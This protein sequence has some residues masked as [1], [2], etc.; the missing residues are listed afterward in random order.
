MFKPFAS[1]VGKRIRSNQTRLLIAAS[2]AILAA[3]AFTLASVAANDAIL[4]R[5]NP[6]QASR[7]AST[8]AQANK[9]YTLYTGF[10][11]TDGSFVSTIRVK[12]VLAVAPIDVTPVLFMADGAP[13][14]LSSVH[15]AVSGVATVNI[16]DALATA[17]SSIASHIS[18]FGSA[19]LIYSYPSPGHVTAQ[20]AAID[21]SRSLSYTY[22]FVEP[23]NMPGHDS[24]QVL[25][26]LWWKHDPGVT[27]FITLSNTTGQ[28]QTA[29]LTPVLPGNNANSQQVT[30]APQS[31][32]MLKLEDIAAEVSPPDNRAGGIR[33]EYEGSQGAILVTGALANES[34]GYSANM[35]FWFQDMNSSSPTQVTYASAGLMLGKPDPMMMPGFPKET[36]FSVYL[37]LRNTTEKPLDVALQLNYMSGTGMRGSAPVARN[38]PM[39]HLAPLEA[40]QVD[41]QG[42]LNAVGLK[43][44]S[45]S[46][47]LSTSF[48]GKAGDLVLATGSV[49]QTGTY[50]FEVEPQGIGTS[51]SKFA[52]YWGVAHGNDTMFSLWNPTDTPQDIV[53]TLY[54]GNAS[55]KYTVPVHL[56]AQ[57]STMIDMAMLIAEIRPDAD[58]NV[59]PPSIQEGSA[60]FAS[61]NGRHEQITLVIAAG[62]YNVSTATCG[63][64]WINCCGG[65]N[66]GISPNPIYCPIGQSMQ[67]GSTAVDCNG[68]S[69]GPSS[70]SSDNPSVMTV[71]G[72]GVVTGVSVGQANIIA[73]YLGAGV[74]TGQMCG[75]NGC[76]SASPAPRAPGYV[77]PYRV[78]P[79]AT[80]SQYPPSTCSPGQD[81]WQRNVTN[82]LQYSNGSPYAHAGIMT[83]DNFSIG[84]RNDL[85][86]TSFRSG[87]AVTTGD[88]SWSD[89]YFVCSSACPVS[90]G[91]T[92]ALQN[93]TAN[94]LPLPHVNLVIYKCSSI[95]I[96]GY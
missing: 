64:G 77:G 51:R 88:G 8:P 62:I 9:T 83:T 82:Q 3:I 17:P 39:Q 36:A 30:L 23:M 27:G 55:G 74:Y 43:N 11:R 21:A 14:M 53:A 60:Q 52:N 72:S 31:T 35:P 19:A 32:Q 47:N 69:F 92:D 44:F 15:V 93:W 45:G 71:N 28:Q 89:Y 58:G 63:G 37:S 24:K 34:E 96:D 40:R 59:I 5:S 65:S 20:M 76:P 2:T 80:A 54:Y 66:F 42:A 57:A 68:Y 49:D 87:S 33:V 95:S 78:E 81:G 7:S 94:G 12:N 16:N 90:T 79:I 84:G 86:V 61:A 18:Q 26:G 10:W 56:D 41:L 25:E 91:E 29:V 38:L 22:P 1:S 4:P 13:Y 48:T 50:V 85:G 67:C 73:T 70:W 46:I 6:A 75:G